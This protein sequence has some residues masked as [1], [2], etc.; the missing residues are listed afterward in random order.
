MNVNDARKAGL[1]GG[2]MVGSLAMGT[3]AQDLP[4]TEGIAADVASRIGES[5]GGTI[6]VGGGGGTV[7]TGGSA[8]GGTISTGDITG[9]GDSQIGSTEGLAVADA[10]GGNSNTSFVS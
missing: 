6:S 3:S 8:G 2:A 1:L 10:S 5:S 9:G 4:T 7:S